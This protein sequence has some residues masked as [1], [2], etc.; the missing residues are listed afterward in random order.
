MFNIDQKNRLVLISR[1]CDLLI[2]R[3]VFLDVAEKMK[4][5]ITQKLSSGGYDK[6]DSPPQLA[7]ALE[8][9][10]RG[11]CKDH[12]LCVGYDPERAKAILDI[13]GKN[14]TQ[15]KAAKQKIF[16]KA[17]ELNFGFA[18]VERLSGN[19]GY[20]DLRFF[21]DLEMSANTATAVFNVLSNFIAVIIDLR[22][23]YG[24]P[25]STVQYYCSYF[26][27]ER[28][29]LNSLV[30]RYKKNPE[31]QYWSLPH[32][33]GNKITG[34][35]VYILTSKFTRSAAEEFAYDLKN[36]GRA[37]IIGE[38]TRG[39]AHD[40]EDVVILDEFVLSL[41]EGRAVNPIT[42]TNWEG[43]GVQ[44]DV[45]TPITKALDTAHLMAIKNLLEN[46]DDDNKKF[47]FNYALLVIQARLSPISLDSKI[48]KSYAGQYGKR[49]ITH[50]NGE[51][52][53]YESDDNATYRLIPLS[54]IRFAAEGVDDFQIEFHVLGDGSVNE[55]F[56]IWDDGFRS[57]V[58][59]TK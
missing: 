13:R 40:E 52:F 26:L 44:P 28:T 9:D 38:A 49:K 34:Q 5:H 8:Q 57:F 25:P 31:E 11:I 32:V 41:P 45:T 55:F 10:L 22:R 16:D 1:I 20:L 33:P 18:K 15:I 43:I 42:N 30:R 29:H 6:L 59:R 14:A 17:K 54:E 47:I 50:E 58:T 2:E 51:V 21:A 4:Q 27:E 7:M 46:E 24:G 19:I 35:D 23:C 12:H 3:Y 48:L 56:I 53:F 39:D 36:L 37:I